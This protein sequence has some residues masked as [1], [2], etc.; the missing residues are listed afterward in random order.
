MYQTAESAAMRS[1]P[2]A[3]S[4][5][6]CCYYRTHR[7]IDRGCDGIKRNNHDL[8]IIRRGGGSVLHFFQPA[9]STT[10]G[11]MDFERRLRI[12]ARLPG[13]KL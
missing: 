4:A 2:Q 13:E 6:G 5:T 9:L 8:P 12:M 3:G 10:T 7:A 11:K 1:S